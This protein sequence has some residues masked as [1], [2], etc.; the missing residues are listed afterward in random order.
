VTVRAVVAA[1]VVAAAAGAEAG[2]NPIKI[3]RDKRRLFFA[4]YS[5]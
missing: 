4:A 1:A 5:F 2:N 3:I